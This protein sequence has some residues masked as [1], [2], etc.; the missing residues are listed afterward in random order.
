MIQIFKTGYEKSST[1]ASCKTTRKKL[2]EIF[3]KPLKFYLTSMNN[4]Q[5]EPPTINLRT[6]S[7]GIIVNAIASTKTHSEAVKP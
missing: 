3:D 7:T 2:A 1:S 6:M 5:V 4:H